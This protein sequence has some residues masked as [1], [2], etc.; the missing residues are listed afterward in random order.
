[1][2]RVLT[3]AVLF[4]LS[5]LVPL[6]EASAQSPFRDLNV[7][8]GQAGAFVYGDLDADGD[9]DLLG[10]TF[11]GLIPLFND[12]LGN[13]AA[14]V[15]VGPPIPN[16][17]GVLS[18]LHLADV[19][20]DGHLDLLVGDRVLQL[21]RVYLG[22]G[23]GSFV[24]NGSVGVPQEPSSVIAAD[25]DGDGDLDAAVAG[26]LADRVRILIND[27]A[28]N[29]TSN[30]DLGTQ[31]YPS[32]M[33][34][35]DWDGDG[36]MD[37]AVANR[38]ADSFSVYLGAGDGSFAAG[39][40]YPTGYN[41]H[42]MKTG[43][44]T[45][46]GIPDLFA[47][48]G[49]TQQDRV[50]V[51]AGVGD[52]T[53]GAP[54]DILTGGDY[55]IDVHL[56]DLDEDQVLDLVATAAI[57]DGITY[58]RGLGGGAYAPPVAVPTSNN[59]QRMGVFDVDDDGDLDAV[60][61]NFNSD[62]ITTLLGRGDGTLAPNY[63]VGHQPFGIAAGDM[64]NDG[65]LD[66]VVTSTGEAPVHVLPGRGDGHFDA[67]VASATGSFQREVALG[68]L[69]NDGN[70]DALV[71]PGTG[72]ISFLAGQGDLTFAAPVTEALTPSIGTFALAHFD[73]DGVLDLAVVAGGFMGTLRVFPG[74]GD[75]TF[76][77]GTAYPGDARGLVLGDFDDDGHTDIAVSRPFGIGVYRGQGDGGF[78]APVESAHGEQQ[79]GRM[80]AG[81]FDGD[82]HLDAALL[83]PFQELTVISGN[84]DGSFGAEVVESTVDGAPLVVA[85]GDY[86]DDGNLDLVVGGTAS[87]TSG[88]ISLHLGQGDG[89]FAEAL[90]LRLGS[91]PQLVASADLNGDGVPDLAWAVADESNSSG[92]DASHV[93]VLL[94]EAG[95][96]E[97]LGHPLA[98]SGGTPTA[99]G[100]GSLEADTPVTLQLRDAL[101]NGTAILVASATALNAPLEGGFL[102][103]FPQLLLFLPLDGMGSFDLTADWP[104]GFPPG[105]ENFFQFWI[106]DA[107][108]PFGWTS[109]NAL[110]G[111]TP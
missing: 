75:G 37:L 29:F 55:P 101:P 41:P 66:L 23:D 9:T 79:P 96:W 78:A 27:G 63:P 11:F 104:T 88:N 45:G 18:G 92:T 4:S 30:G 58:R 20:G 69:D 67:S 94:S 14:D 36:D 76:G 59:P 89:T 56:A 74:E 17:G 90:W 81:D 106:E 34:T 61:I 31:D 46:D 19:D 12:G 15:E 57:A 48:V 47:G 107:G 99:L 26:Q 108:G 32:S 33:A 49:H 82:G 91:E 38:H 25:W 40:V 102:V 85:A 83:G 109:S 95:P 110:R 16:S 64:D 51:I 65:H 42:Q 62:I 111:V 73:G 72:N 100:L 3:A 13:F 80:A 84:G 87:F 97:N 105:F 28:G 93:T 103:P 2:F 43:D 22:N 44:I 7:S 35:A 60:V 68:D 5:G 71:S 24:A 77:A 21:M 98:G 39:V 10:Y 6:D 52:G 53:F 50:T 86:D 1:M 70:L 8:V 54:F